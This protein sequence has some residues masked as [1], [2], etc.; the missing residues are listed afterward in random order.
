MHKTL[1]PRMNAGFPGRSLGECSQRIDPIGKILSPC[2]ED[3]GIFPFAKEGY[4]NLTFL[5]TRLSTARGRARKCHW[6]VRA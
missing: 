1:S 4:R 6:Q 5:L 3:E 2:R